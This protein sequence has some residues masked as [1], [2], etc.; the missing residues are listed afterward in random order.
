MLLL[1]PTPL[2]NLKDITLR[3]LE[4]LAQADIVLCEDTRVAKRL[5]TLLY[6]RFSRV[7]CAVDLGSS[8]ESSDQGCANLDS[9]R[10]SLDPM[11]KRFISLHSHNETEFF[12]TITPEF[13][14]DNVIYISDAG[15][16]C[17]CDPGA[18]LVEYC[19]KHEIAYDVLPGACALITAFAHSGIGSQGFVFGGFLAHKQQEREE[20]ILRL[21]DSSTKSSHKAQESSPPIIMYESPHRLLES[22]R[23]LDKLAPD[24]MLIAT[25][26]LTKAHQYHARGTPK[27]VLAMLSSRNIQG[28]WTLVLQPYV[29]MLSLTL[30]ENDIAELPLPPKHKAK[31]LSRL[32]GMD[33]KHIYQNLIQQESAPESASTFTPKNLY[34]NTNKQKGRR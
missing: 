9:A 28:E 22:L 32:T 24:S 19:V 3:S 29:P 10:F 13:F 15:M 23:L 12:S 27:E 11:T 21:L 26:E 5:Y 1:V 6:D 14:A 7:L 4:A 33:T 25:K 34:Q 31:L 30:Y 2:G 18:R 17:V 16:P 20:Q 8:P